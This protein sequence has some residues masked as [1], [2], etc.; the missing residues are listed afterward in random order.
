MY[1]YQLH[2]FHNS[3]GVRGQ[4][5]VNRGHNSQNMS[6]YSN[7]TQLFSQ[8]IISVKIIFYSVDYIEIDCLQNSAQSIEDKGPKSSF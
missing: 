4:P 2:P 1:V 8:C 7:V 3:Y 6:F 5:E